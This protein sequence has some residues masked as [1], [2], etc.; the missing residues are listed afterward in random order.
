MTGNELFDYMQREKFGVILESEADAYGLTEMLVHADL[1]AMASEIPLWFRERNAKTIVANYDSRRVL[2]S[3]DTD[4][5]NLKDYCNTLIPF[6][7][8]VIQPL[9]V[10]ST[11][12]DLL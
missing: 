3:R 2:Y 6:S 7:Q 9:P 8:L 4:L 1:V 10:I 5:S 12:D 11:I